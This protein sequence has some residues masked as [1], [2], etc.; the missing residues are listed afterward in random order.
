MYAVEFRTKIKDGTVEVPSQ[1]QTKLK[2]TVRVIILVEEE[3]TATNMIEHLM[4]HPLQ[5]P[6]FKPMRRSEIYDR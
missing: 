1:Y 2:G 6:G 3:Q 4:Q 5:A